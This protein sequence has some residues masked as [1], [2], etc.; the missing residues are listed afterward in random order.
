MSNEI[1]S[2]GGG[3]D[4]WPLPDREQFRQAIAPLRGYVYQL[5]HSLTAWIA[6][7]PG[8]EPRALEQ[9]RTNGTRYLYVAAYV[10]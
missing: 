4:P 8:A 7:P 10:V 5:H 3:P 1:P 2:F 6:L 9:V